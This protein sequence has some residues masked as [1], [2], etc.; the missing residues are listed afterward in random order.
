MNAG[1]A[2]ATR[3]I[4]HDVI[5]DRRGTWAMLLFISTEATL[6]LILFFSYYYLAHVSRG[7]WPPEPPKLTLALI[8]LG[9]LLVSSGV[10]HWGE[11]AEKAG[12]K[13]AAK[14]AIGATVILG[15]GFH[16]LQVFEYRE[17]LKT[18]KPTTDAYGSIFYTITSFHAAHLILGLLMLC[19]VFA[20]PEIGPG[21]KPPHRALHNAGLYWHFVDLIWLI[22]VVL[23]YVVPNIRR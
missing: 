15:L 23:L 2:A 4:P 5:D 9:V 19:Y 12:R 18:M 1:V 21:R 14:L 7:P 6:F 17:H 20:L 22:V 10:L 3:P 11:L 16:T 13:A 8:M